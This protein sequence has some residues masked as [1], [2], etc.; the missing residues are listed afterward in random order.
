LK[1][2][3]TYFKKNLKHKNNH[4][5]VYHD[6]VEYLPICTWIKSNQDMIGGKVVFMR[7][8]TFHMRIEESIAQKV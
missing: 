3:K 6:C 8:S 2:I 1:V 5:T 4:D 7:V